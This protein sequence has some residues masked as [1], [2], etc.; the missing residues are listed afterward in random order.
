MGGTTKQLEASAASHGEVFGLERE[1]GADVREVEDAEQ[2]GFAVGDCAAGLRGE[3]QRAAP[4][5]KEEGER[6][7]DAR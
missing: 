3:D 4:R 7:L 2:A 5:G 6:S 1:H